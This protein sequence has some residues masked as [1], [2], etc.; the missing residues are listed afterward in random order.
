MIAT[1]KKAIEPFVSWSIAAE[2]IAE[3]TPD[4]DGVARSNSGTLIADWKMIRIH[5]V[6]LYTT[7]TQNFY[8]RLLRVQ[9]KSIALSMAKLIEVLLSMI[10]WKKLQQRLLDLELERWMVLKE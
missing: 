7:V 10:Q 1:F 3:M 6:V 4:K 5:L 2:T 9:K 8:Q